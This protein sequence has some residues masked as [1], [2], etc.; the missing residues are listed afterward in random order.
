MSASQAFWSPQR[1]LQPSPVPQPA[2]DIAVIGDHALLQF[3]DGGAVTP[4]LFHHVI[5]T[6]DQ[7]I[8]PSV[9]QQPVHEAGIGSPNIR[10]PERSKVRLQRSRYLVLVTRRPIGDVRYFL[11]KFISRYRR[12]AFRH[13]ENRVAEFQAFRPGILIVQDIG[14]KYAMNS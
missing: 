1:L 14:A 10:A 11:A 7:P 2:A 12:L 5:K 4:M 9:I 6:I 3:P 13:L 8:G